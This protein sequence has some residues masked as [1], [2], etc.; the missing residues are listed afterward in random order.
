MNRVV[1]GNVQTVFILYVIKRNYGKKIEF[2]PLELLLEVGFKISDR[3]SSITKISK[4]LL[5]FIEK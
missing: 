5:P 4:F 1:C 3:R 2:V